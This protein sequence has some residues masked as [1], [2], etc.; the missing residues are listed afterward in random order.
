MP[1]SFFAVCTVFKKAFAG[2]IRFNKMH[3]A[4][5]RRY[6]TADRFQ[7]AQNFYAKIRRQHF[8]MPSAS[9]G[10]SPPDPP[11]GALPLDSTGGTALRPPL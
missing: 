11:P 4:T 10:L 7:N 9:G 2:F 6:G 8:E 3:H 1:V 5:N